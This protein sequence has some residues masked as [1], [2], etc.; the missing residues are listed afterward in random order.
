MQGCLAKAKKLPKLGSETKSDI[1]AFE[2][3]L[4]AAA[5]EKQEEQATAA[6]ALQHA[7]APQ[8]MDTTTGQSLQNAKHH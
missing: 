4:E 6:A 8:E 3:K 1:E 2:A 7:A 5:A